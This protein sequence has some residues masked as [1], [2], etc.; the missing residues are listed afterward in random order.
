MERLIKVVVKFGDFWSS[1]GFSR[2]I[3]YGHGK[4]MG[5]R[6]ELKIGVAIEDALVLIS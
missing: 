3:K 1:L 4:E 2:N 6:W 5:G